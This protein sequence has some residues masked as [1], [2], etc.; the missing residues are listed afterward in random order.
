MYK[1]SFQVFTWP[2]ITSSFFNDLDKQVSVDLR[3]IRT[4]AFD[5]SFL[6]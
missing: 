1:D 4:F 3:I 6:L 5:L 2:R